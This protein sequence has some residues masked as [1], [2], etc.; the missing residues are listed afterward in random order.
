[1]DW[2]QERLQ[3]ASVIRI[4]GGLLVV[5]LLWP[6]SGCDDAVPF[7]VNRGNPTSVAIVS[8]TSGLSPNTAGA[9][10]TVSVRLTGSDTGPVAGWP[11]A[12]VSTSGSSL[13]TAPQGSVS[14]DTT[15]SNV[16][17]VADVT[18]TLGAD[19]ETYYLDIKAARTARAGAAG[20]ETV[21]PQSGP[22]LTIVAQ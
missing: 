11:V 14:A 2:Y 8:D 10:V 21:S 6:F 17:G 13:S 22:D 12:W 16:D 9:Q 20:S 5:A 1:M 7:D 3:G 4:A 19:P 15:Y 18:W